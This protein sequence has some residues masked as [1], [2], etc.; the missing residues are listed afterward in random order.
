MFLSNVYIENNVNIEL[1]QLL[2][3]TNIKYGRFGMHSNS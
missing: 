1:Y 2:Y 3:K